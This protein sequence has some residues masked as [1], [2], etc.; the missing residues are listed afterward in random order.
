MLPR[1]STAAS[2]AAFFLFA[3]FSAQAA[4]PFADP[5]LAAAAKTFEAALVKQLQPPAST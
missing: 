4:E 3:S 1:S 2:V 5:N